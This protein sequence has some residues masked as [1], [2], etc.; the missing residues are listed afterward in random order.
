MLNPR[1]ASWKVVTEG[2]AVVTMELRAEY[3]GAGLGTA[4]LDVDIELIRPPLLSLAAA[5]RWPTV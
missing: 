4:N 2:L 1:D 5:H 3:E